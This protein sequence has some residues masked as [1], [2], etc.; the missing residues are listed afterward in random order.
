MGTPLPP[1]VAD[2][3]RF[4]RQRRWNRLELWLAMIVGAVAAVLLYVR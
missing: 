4:R 3:E 2:P 1:P